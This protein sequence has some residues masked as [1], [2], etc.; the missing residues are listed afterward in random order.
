MISYIYWFYDIPRFL[1]SNAHLRYAENESRR[2]AKP[3]QYDSLRPIDFRHTQT[4]P[5]FTTQKQQTRRVN[6]T[7]VESVIFILFRWT[8]L[9]QSLLL[10]DFTSPQFDNW[11]HTFNVFKEALTLLEFIWWA[12]FVHISSNKIYW[13]IAKLLYIEG[14]M[15]KENSELFE[16]FSIFRSFSECYIF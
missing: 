16:F 6:K 9:F 13:F 3:R 10:S 5:V 11:L 12:K 4:G 15:I 7:R 8:G 14:E 2:K 1:W